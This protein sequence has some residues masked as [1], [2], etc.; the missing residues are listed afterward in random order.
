M[1]MWG[2]S[3]AWSW[4]IIDPASNKSQTSECRSAQSVQRNASQQRAKTS[5]HHVKDEWCATS[6]NSPNRVRRTVSEENVCKPTAE[7]AEALPFLKV[8][9]EKDEKSRIRQSP[10]SVPNLQPSFDSTRV[11]LQQGFPQLPTRTLPCLKFSSHKYKHILTVM[12]TDQFNFFR[13]Q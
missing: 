2:Q 11:V 9:N 7:W 12:K 13:D 5:H 1:L 8:P 6:Q 10:R 4:I 3:M